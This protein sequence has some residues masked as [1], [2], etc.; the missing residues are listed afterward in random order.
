VIWL[1]TTRLVEFYLFFMK[2]K[3]SSVCGTLQVFT[4]LV[5]IWIFCSATH[6]EYW[7][8]ICVY[9]VEIWRFLQSVLVAGFLPCLTVLIILMLFHALLLSTAIE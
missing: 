9:C 8:V 6:Y 1:L 4:V 5:V 7:D 2:L 3:S